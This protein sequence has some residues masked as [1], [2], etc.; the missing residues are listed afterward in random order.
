MVY[1]TGTR[2]FTP[3]SG[4]SYL[5][6]QHL[7]RAFRVDASMISNDDLIS[8][9]LGLVAIDCQLRQ[10]LVS[11]PFQHSSTFITISVG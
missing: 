8:M 5:S 1:G 4:L 6:A 11:L 3:A 10:G 7:L 2:R 9:Q